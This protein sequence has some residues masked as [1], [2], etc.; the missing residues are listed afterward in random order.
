[1]M[2]EKEHRYK[3]KEKLQFFCD[4]GVAL[5]RRKNKT[6]DMMMLFSAS[7]SSFIQ[8]IHQSLRITKTSAT[9]DRD[10][11]ACVCVCV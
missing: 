5:T 9:R 3:G 1:M 6:K 7:S 10:T 4:T 8:F 11:K 2:I